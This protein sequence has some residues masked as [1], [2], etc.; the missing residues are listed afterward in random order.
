MNTAS[1]PV[2]G[3]SRA[4]IDCMFDRSVEIE[5]VTHDFLEKVAKAKG[6]RTLDHAFRQ[7]S[8]LLAHI[9]TG[10]KIKEFEVLTV[11]VGSLYCS[12]SDGEIFDMTARFWNGAGAP[13]SKKVAGE[14]PSTRDEVPFGAAICFTPQACTVRLVHNKTRLN[15]GKYDPVVAAKFFKLCFRDQI[16]VETIT[17]VF[18][19]C[20]EGCERCPI[21]PA[22]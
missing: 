11:R 17:R 15:L 12:M 22:K 10:M 14:L 2:N 9:V 20:C 7:M 21:T 5:T 13:A 18:S 3:F 8:E 1:P 6:Q 4:A 16:P 19:E